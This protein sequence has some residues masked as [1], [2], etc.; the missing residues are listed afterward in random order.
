MN[1]KQKFPLHTQGQG[2]LD[3]KNVIKQ[4]QVPHKSSMP[5]ISINKKLHTNERKA[6]VICQFKFK[7]I[8]NKKGPHYIPCFTLMGIF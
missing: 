3:L 4:I 8:R 2:N 7:I 5:R 1:Q 6:V